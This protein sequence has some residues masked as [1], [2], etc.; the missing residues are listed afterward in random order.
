MSDLENRVRQIEWPEP[1]DQLRTR[2]IDTAVQPALVTWSDRIWFSRTWRVSF[3]AAMLALIAI[4]QLV[5]RGPAVPVDPSSVEA[6]QAIESAVIDAGIPADVAAKLARRALMTQ[7]APRA[8]LAQL[9]KT[10]GDQ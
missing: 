1:S 4:G 2:V 5:G 6:A 8:S 10:F 3:A 9:M 7:Q